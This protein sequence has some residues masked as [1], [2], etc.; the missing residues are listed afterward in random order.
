MAPSGTRIVVRFFGGW[1][2][3]KGLRQ[4]NFVQAGYRFGVP[5]GGELGKPAGGEA[6][7]FLV[8]ARWDEYLK[9]PLQQI[10]I[11]KGWVDQ[12]GS[13]THEK[14]FTV[15]A[16]DLQASVSN[17]CEPI[18]KVHQELFGV[19]KDPE[20]D[21][22]VPAFYYVRVL[23]NPVCRYSTLICQQKYGINPLATGCADQLK[24]LQLSADPKDRAKAA[25]AAYCCS[26]ETTSPIVQPVIQERAWTS[27]IWYTPGS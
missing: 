2:F 27:P 1:N 12:Q 20:F 8:F 16:G 13:Q 24:A 19:F 17:S 5:M 15:V 10:Q 21:P 6:P 18:G 26:N 11:V 4:D 14:V 25:D 23:E 7:S 9:T 3:P 22:K